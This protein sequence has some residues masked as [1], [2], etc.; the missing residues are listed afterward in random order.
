MVDDAMADDALSLT[1][2]FAYDD[3]MLL[4][5]L[6]RSLI[7]PGFG[8]GPGDMDRFRRIALEWLVGHAEQLRQQVCNNTVVQA[9]SNDELGGKVS[10]A[11][12][13]EYSIEWLTCA[14]ASTLGVVMVGL[15]GAAQDHVLAY[16]P[17]ALL[18][19]PGVL[20]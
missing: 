11:V 10:D 9:I 5:E 19:R 3:D 4:E 8:F 12:P 6:G 1:D 18:G 14:F 16:V 2:L 17:G 15:A 13:L 20:R 7:G